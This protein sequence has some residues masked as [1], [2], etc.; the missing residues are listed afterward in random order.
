MEVGCGGNMGTLVSIYLPE[1]MG[2]DR[3]GM[4]Q[5]FRTLADKSQR[6][7]PAAIGQETAGRERKRD[8]P[9]W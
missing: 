1:E 7:A 2:R 8:I 6:E 3:R 4:A 5:R 9:R